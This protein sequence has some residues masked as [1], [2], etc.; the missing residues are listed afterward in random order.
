MSEQTTASPAPK[1]SPALV[2]F[3]LGYVRRRAEVQV[4]EG[5]ITREDMTR[6]LTQRREV[7]ATMCSADLA[8]KVLIDLEPGE[9]YSDVVGP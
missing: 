6:A 7:F 1:A 2:D 9:F 3:T 5:A 8:A 4:A